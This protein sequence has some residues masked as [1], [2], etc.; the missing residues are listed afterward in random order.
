MRIETELIDL[1]PSLE[2]AAESVRPIAA[3]KDI[4]FNVE[5]AREP[6]Y[7]KGDAVR[8]QQVITNLLQNAIKFTGTGGEVSLTWTHEGPDVVIE[9]S[10]TGIGIEKDFL[11]IIFD[12]FSQADASTRRNNTGLGLGLTI[13]R[14]IVE[15]HGGTTAAHSDGPST[16][17]SFSVKLPL[18]EEFYKQ[19]LPQSEPVTNN[20][21]SDSLSGV[22]ILLVDDDQDGLLPLRYLLENEKALVTCVL[23]AG[24]ALDELEERDFDI[25]ISDIG[26]P[27]MDGFELISKLRSDRGGRNYA[28]KAIAYTAY[29][30]EDD[31][32]RILSSTMKFILQS[33]STWMSF[34]GSCVNSAWPKLSIITAINCPPPPLLLH[35]FRHL[36][37]IMHA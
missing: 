26:M 4:Y 10:D 28:V 33:L 36:K 14:T 30:S 31:K 29:A 20:S 2:Q 5:I 21:R 25:L 17:A 27:F 32:N 7:L 37:D 1:V 19:L 13:V 23:S 35:Q 6:L 18:A 9:V 3:A 24:E 16:G 8:L 11:P 15:L 12:R 34:Y 22:R